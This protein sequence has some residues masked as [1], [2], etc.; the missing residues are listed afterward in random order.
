MPP[1]HVGS[2][3]E[4][5]AKLIASVQAWTREVG[6]DPALWASDDGRSHDAEGTEGQHPVGDESRPAA[7]TDATEQ[8]RWHDTEQHTPLECRVCPVCNVGRFARTM[9]PEIRGHLASAGMSLALAVKGLLEGMDEQ[10]PGANTAA[11]DGP[12]KPAGSA[13]SAHIDLTED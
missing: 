3:A 6:A 2:L 12:S 8:D 13:P 9:T 1:D 7:A 4:E 5:A 11:D 10:G